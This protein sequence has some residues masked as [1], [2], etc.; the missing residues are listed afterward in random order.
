MTRVS[1][2]TPDGAA[3]RMGGWDLVLGS[4]DEPSLCDRV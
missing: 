2:S 1:T 4:L 3:D